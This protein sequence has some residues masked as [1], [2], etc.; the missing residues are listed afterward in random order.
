MQKAKHSG[1]LLLLVAL[2]LLSSWQSQEL[3]QRRRVQTLGMNEIYSAQAPAALNFVMVGLGGFRGLVAEV[4][5]FRVGRL[6]MEG[7]YLELVQ[8][9]NWITMLDPK[10]SEGWTFNSWNLAYNISVMMNRPEDRLR[11][12]LSGISLLR[13]QALRF[14]PRDAKLYR[15]LAW[16]YQHKIGENLDTAHAHYKAYL[17]ECLAPYVNSNGTVCVSESSR[18][19]LIMM[20]LDMG[21]MVALEKKYGPLDWR[22]A[23]T[24]A[25]YWASLGSSCA[26]GADVLQCEYAVNQA[27]MLSVFRGRFAGSVSEKKWRAAPNLALALS[28]ADALLVTSRNSHSKYQTLLLIRYLAKTV[29]LAVKAGESEMAQQLYERLKN[30]M[31]APHQ[32]PTFDEVAKGW[33]SKQ[34]ERY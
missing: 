31:P 15:E 21:Q 23:E 10:A 14:N 13:D 17:L 8:L 1:V 19:A 26:K 20:R 32:V 18:A 5:W 29:R 2:C 30:V 28:A 24:H 6:Q 4:L 16:M 27:L 12:V 3:A 11:W 7:R 33:G 34:G 22:M 25:L 9:A